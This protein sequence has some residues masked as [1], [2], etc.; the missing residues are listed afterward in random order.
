MVTQFGF[1]GSPYDY[2]IGFAREKRSVSGN[3]RRIEPAFQVMRSWSSEVR[4]DEGFRMPVDEMHFLRL[5]LSPASGS[6]SRRN[7]RETGAELIRGYGDL[8]FYGAGLSGD[9]ARCGI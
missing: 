2:A 9:G 1:R 7:P 4:N 6:L 8:V 3:V 5:G